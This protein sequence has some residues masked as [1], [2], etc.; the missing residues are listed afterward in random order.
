LKSSS[1]G[2]VSVLIASQALIRAEPGL[3]LHPAMD[4]WRLQLQRYRQQWYQ[5]RA[6]LPVSL[7]AG[8]QGRCESELLA[9][10]M[11]ELPEQ[12][13]QCWMASPYHAQL[14][15]D[16]VILLPDGMLPLSEQDANW[17]C[18]QLNPMLAEDGMTLVSRGAALLLCCREKLHASPA[19]FGDISGKHLPD[20]HAQGADDG[21][22]MRLQSEIQ[23]LLHRHPADHRREKGE[24]DIHGL[25]LWA[26][27]EPMPSGIKDYRVATRNPCLQSMVDGRDANIIIS[28]AERLSELLKEDAR[29]PAHVLLAGEG[30]AVL[31][32]K[33]VFRGFAKARWQPKSVKHESELFSLL[34]GMIHVA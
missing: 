15:R 5:C 4:Q 26:P 13:T 8:L 34:R 21:H 10:L 23:M 11:P 20:R 6:N 22:L 16:S 7:Y 2:G 24:Q 27:G 29:L 32:S 14:S 12:T 30:H 31:L 33:S 9:T 19:S 28:E 25:W 18:R 17:L 3:A 1:D